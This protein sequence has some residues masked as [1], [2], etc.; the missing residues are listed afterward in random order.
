MTKRPNGSDAVELQE[1]GDNCEDTL[2]LT[3]RRQ[4]ED[5]WRDLRF[6]TSVL[7]LWWGVWTIADKTMIAYSPWSEIAAIVL[8]ASLCFWDRARAAVV[9]Q[10]GMTRTAVMTAVNRI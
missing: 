7:L 6:G 4:P 2:A 5:V 9:A 1:V 10:V 3:A 8:G